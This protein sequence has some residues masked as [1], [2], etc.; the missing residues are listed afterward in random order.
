VGVP[1]SVLKDK[2][3]YEG[4]TFLAWLRE[5]LAAKG[6]RTFRDLVHPEFASDP[7]YRYR[8]Q[9][10]ASDVTARRLLVLPRDAPLY[11][12]EPDDLDVAL[13]VRM[14]ASVPFYFE[15]VLLP[16]AETG[17]DHVI[18]D[19]GVLSNFPVWLFDVEGEPPWPTFGL[20]LVE[21]DPSTPLGD[22]LPRRGPSDGRV[23]GLLDYVRSLI[24]TMV[25]AHDRLYVEKAAFARTIP[26][27]TLGVGTTEFG[28][29][30]RRAAELYAAG[31][32]AAEAFLAG[33]DFEGYVAEFRR[34]KQHSRRAELAA[35]MRRAAAGDLAGSGAPA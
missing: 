12:I 31:R 4:R 32:S 15:P 19:G 17:E 13:A 6:V 24:A 10:V 11:G 34:G 25:E 20:L 1:L 3:L 5:R 2:G 28:L 33:W 27:S 7:R 26:I 23:G 18:V 9:V 16:D 8:V 21:P 35:A 22:R 29:G 30:S 14:S